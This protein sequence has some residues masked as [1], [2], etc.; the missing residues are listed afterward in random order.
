M[1]LQGL[2]ASLRCPTVE[3]TTTDLAGEW[4]SQ[5]RYLR[6]VYLRRSKPGLYD[7]AT[8]HLPRFGA[9]CQ[10]GE[11]PATAEEAVSCFGRLSTNGNYPREFMDRFEDDDVDTLQSSIEDGEFERAWS[12]VE[13]SFLREPA[14]LGQSSRAAAP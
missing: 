6:Q 2:G 8:L 1:D 14:I 9:V 12:F 7:A 13:S 11:V 4:A 10:S 5:A 3:D